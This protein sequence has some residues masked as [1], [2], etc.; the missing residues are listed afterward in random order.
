M[1]FACVSMVTSLKRKIVWH[2]LN[3]FNIITKA[4]EIRENSP[5]EVRE[6]SAG[7]VEDR[8][9][10]E[11]EIREILSKEFDTALLMLGLP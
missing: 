4:L 8:K 7:E 2:Y 10:T 5:V 3:R 1:G 6:T 11:E 9:V